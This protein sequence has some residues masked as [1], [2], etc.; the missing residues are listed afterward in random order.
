MT[1]QLRPLTMMDLRKSP[2][3]IL[4]RVSRDGEAFVIERNG[5][6]KAF[7]VPISVFWPDIQQRRITLELDELKKIGIKPQMSITDSK[8]LEMR[9][10]ESVGDDQITL[11]IVL[12]HIKTQ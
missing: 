2:G 11:T 5:Q 3:S 8:E 4:D 1:L 6:D 10:H 9:F 12:S 7:L